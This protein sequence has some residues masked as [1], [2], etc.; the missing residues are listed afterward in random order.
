MYTSSTG[1]KSALKVASRFGWTPGAATL[2]A[3]KGYGCINRTFNSPNN[4][5]QANSGGTFKLISVWYD[6]SSF[7]TFTITKYS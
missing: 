4:S 3:L 2:N 6:T 7:T 1:A 5:F